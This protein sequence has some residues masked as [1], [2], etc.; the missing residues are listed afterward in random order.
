M[1]FYTP[2]V[3]DVQILNSLMIFCFFCFV[4]R[5]AQRFIMIFSINI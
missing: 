2:R 5:I 3:Y 1:S 4:A